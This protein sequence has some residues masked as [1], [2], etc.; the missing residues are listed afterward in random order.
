MVDDLDAVCKANDLA[1]M[2]TMDTI[3]LGVVV[4]WAMESYEKGAITKEDTEG[5]D[6]ELGQWRSYG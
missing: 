6:F 1:N 2:Y 5:L 3:S 4:A